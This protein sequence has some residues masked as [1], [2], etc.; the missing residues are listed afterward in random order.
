MAR[1]GE[2]MYCVPITYAP[3][4]GESNLNPVG[5]GIRILAMFVRNLLWSPAKTKVR[6]IAFV[7]DSVMPYFNGGKE[8][9]L[10]EVSNRLVNEECEVHIYTMKWWEGPNVITNEGGVRLHAIC[11]LYP[12][13]KKNRRSIVQALMFGLA[14]FNLAF[15]R[16]DVLDVDH[17]PFFPLISARIVTWLR[18]RKLYGTWHEVWGRE[19][20]MQYLRGPAGMLGFLTEE[21]S[22]RLPDVIISNSVHTTK[23]LRAAGCK[24]EI[25]T[26]PLGVDLKRIYMTQAETR[27]S[28]VIFVGRLLEHKNADMLVKAIAI[29]KEK[30][31]KISCNIIGDGPERNRIEA[32]IEELGLRTNITIIDRVEGNANLYSLLKASKMLVLPSVR[33]GFGLV[34]IEARASGLPVIT[35]SHENNAAK[36][37]VKHGINGLITEPN[38]R[39]IGHAIVWLLEQP[40]QVDRSLDVEEHD[41]SHVSQRLRA[42]LT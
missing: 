39:D 6:R 15:E 34:A 33:E 41:W 17:M 5:D 26:I 2:E 21:L 29:A 3:R 27:T 7:S 28:D 24:Q 31:E 25:A 18:G 38:E 14:T 12:L 30:Y 37:L 36:D 40:L 4:S 23:H 35:T 16:F 20:W 1:L 10:F 13:Y 9:R 11:K 22:L 19:Y 32:L 42:A 8:K